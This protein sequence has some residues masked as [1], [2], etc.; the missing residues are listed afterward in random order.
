MAKHQNS[1]LSSRLFLALLVSIGAYCLSITSSSAQTDGAFGGNSFSSVLEES[2]FLRV[3]DAFI[4]T[5]RWD[6]DQQA[7][8]D[9]YIEPDYY[10]YRA[11]FVYQTNS[12]SEV[13]ASYPTG[14]TKFDEFFQEDLEVYYSNLLIDLDIPEDTEKLYVQ[15][16]GCAEA[17]LCY[18]PTWVGFDIDTGTGSAGFMGELPSG[19]PLPL[20]SASGPVATAL[21]ANQG[22]DASDEGLPITLLIGFFAGLAVLAGIVLF[23][24]KKG[25]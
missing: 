2:P 11:R 10:L 18:P 20:A 13:T 5:L 24:F 9:W 8:L 12:T 23:S 16:Q 22:T 25:K 14:I 19:P 1:H 4:P 3:G 21:A 15:F 7:Q 6:L 17:G